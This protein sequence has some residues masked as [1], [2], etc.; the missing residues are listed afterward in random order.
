MEHHKPHNSSA[1]EGYYS[2][3][4]LPSG[5]HLAVICCKIRHAK[6]K[7]NMLS[8]TYVPANSAQPFQKEVWA[9]SMQMVATSQGFRIN[10]P[11]IGF[12][13]WSDAN[14]TEYNLQHEEFS[15]KARSTTRTPWSKT[16]STPEGLLVYLPLPLHWHVQ[17]L[18]S[19]CDFSL[20]IPHY[21]VST[22]DSQGKAS[23]HDEKNWARSFPSAH[24][25]LQARDGEKSFC[26][27]GG[28]ILGMEAFLLGY[29]SADMSIDF[30]PPFS[31]RLAG[32]SPFMAYETNWESG[33]FSLQV[34]SF[35]KKL[36]V[37]A[38]APKGTYF[39]LSSPFVEGHRE[40]YLGQSFQATIEVKVFE[41][42]WFSEWH[43]VG[44]H[45]F[46]GGS[47]E[48]GGDYYPPRG[49]EQRFH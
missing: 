34:Q 11:G 48:F 32:L 25:W 47:L 16:T 12:I 20:S 22:E 37:S 30:R 36:V 49:S 4:D 45:V 13:D 10:V 46:H 21:D 1:F 15:L 14:V 42:G 23:V 18:N 31:L 44:Q 33:K 8:F 2:K 24:M 27:A 41:S 3:F 29:R 40:N 38:Q 5:A 17:S 7:P 19:Q 6:E 39:S 28:Q 35:R 26:C 43:L 9:D